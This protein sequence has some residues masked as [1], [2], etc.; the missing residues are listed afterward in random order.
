MR[1]V[2]MHADEADIDETLVHRLVAEQF[3]DWSGLSVEPVESSGTDNA[4][5]R[6]GEEMVV[7]LPRIP[8]AVNGVAHELRWLPRLA[9]HLPVPVPRPLREGRPT[10][11]YPW[12]W[13]VYQWLE[14]T[15]PRVDSLADPDG[16]AEDLAEFVAAL[17]AVDPIGGPAAER[18]VPLAERDAPTRAALAQL[19]GEI[20][21]AAATAV[22]EE[23]LRVPE[24]RGPAVWM[25]ADLSPGNLLTVDGRLGAVIDFAAAGTGDPTVDL[26]VAWNLLPASARG[27]FRERLD[28]DEATWIRGRGWALSIALI[29]LPYYRHTNPVLAAN[30]R[31]VI[32]EVLADPS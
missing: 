27:V 20:D 16:L 31:H 12:P 4:M 7:R 6:L 19:E 8:G 25:H 3:P 1:A 11:A 18:G 2:R 14:G 17:R 23:A 5:Y 30:A 24:R 22:W 9:A 21:V 13:S 32:G 10:P 29:Q 26:I 15:N 28:V